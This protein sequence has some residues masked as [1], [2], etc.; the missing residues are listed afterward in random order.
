M[1]TVSVYREFWILLLVAMVFSTGHR[2]VKRES[3]VS[4]SKRWPEIYNDDGDGFLVIGHRGARAYYPEN[5]MPSF[6]G[7]LEKGAEMIEL[8]V[9][10]SKDGVPVVFHDAGLKRCTNGRGRVSD[11]TLEELR[12]LDAGSWFAHRFAGT[13]IPTLREVLSFAAGTIALNIEIKTEAVTDSLENGV[14]EKCLRMVKQFG[15]EDHV[16]FSSFDYRA[17]QHLRQLD[18]HIPVALLY[19]KELSQGKSPAQLTQAYDVDAFNCSRRELGRRWAR[20]LRK[21][22]I[23]FLVYTVNNPKHMRQLIENG[24]AGIFT[25]KPDLL[26]KVAETFDKMR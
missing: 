21:H 6:R 14:E 26:R 23:P 2:P 11:Y 10:L 12:Q 24:A 5:T 3:P 15:M 8:D 4:E 9:Q 7:A 22:E 13:R 18:R 19:N 20:N 17:L 25:D 16:I 1:H